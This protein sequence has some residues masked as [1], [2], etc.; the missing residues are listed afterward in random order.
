MKIVELNIITP[1]IIQSLNFNKDSVKSTLSRLV[2]E[3]R[4]IRLKRGVYIN[5]SADI[6]LS[7]LSNLIF[8]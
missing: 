6:N 8:Q 3:G 7:E 4:F 5:S 1:E 2:K